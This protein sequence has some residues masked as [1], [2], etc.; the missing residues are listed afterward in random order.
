MEKR[1]VLFRN[2]KPHG[3]EVLPDIF[4]EHGWVLQTMDTAK[5]G[6]LQD[7][8]HNDHNLLILSKTANVFEKSAWPLVM[9]VGF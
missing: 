8:A 1:L 2:G 9:S 4:R 3:D 6:Y 7:M 5:G